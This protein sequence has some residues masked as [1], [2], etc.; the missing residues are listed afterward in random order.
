[1]LGLTSRKRLTAAGVVVVLATAGSAF[2]FWTGSG[3]GA[4]SAAV[5][6]SGTITLSAT[7]D[8]GIAPGTSGPVAFTAANPSGSPITVGT[9]SLVG[10]TVDAGHVAC[11]TADFSMAAVAQAY[12]VPANATSEPLPNGGT[13][14]FANTANNQDACKGATLTLQLSSN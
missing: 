10:V 5:G 2:A 8:A 9:V 6:T 1:M 4:G 13:L 11:E 14:V 7:F 12:E 3:G